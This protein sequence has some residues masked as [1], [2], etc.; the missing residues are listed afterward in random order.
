MQISGHKNIQ[1]VM[2]YSKMS[3]KQHRLCSDI[4]SSST[5]SKIHKSQTV[6]STTIMH[7]NDKENVLTKSSASTSHGIGDAESRFAIYNQS[8]MS[9]R[10]SNHSGS[11]NEEVEYPTH[12]MQDSVSIPGAIPGVPQHL[13]SLFSGATLNITNLNLFMNGKN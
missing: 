13:Q 2:T 3:D 10:Q 6:S 7:N 5:T 1:S 9:N 12:G 11:S 4:L 8:V